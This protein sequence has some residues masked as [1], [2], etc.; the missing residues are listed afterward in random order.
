MSFI[1]SLF[2]GSQAKKNDANALRAQ[3]DQYSGE[4]RAQQTGIVNTGFDTARTDLGTG[5]AGA[6]TDLG[7]YYGDAGHLLDTGYATATDKLNTGYDTTKTGAATDFDRAYG[8]ADT[9]FGDAINYATDY[10][11]MGHDALV[12][13]LGT[14]S[15]ANTALDIYNTGGAGGSPAMTAARASRDQGLL[16]QNQ[17]ALAYEA[18]QRLQAANAG[19]GGSRGGRALLADRRASTQALAGLREADLGHLTEQAQRGQ[20]AATVDAQGRYHTGDVLSSVAGQQGAAKT[21]IAMQQANLDAQIEQAR[22]QGNVALVNALTN[23]KTQLATM[24]GNNLASLDTSE[25][26]AYAGLDTG[27]AGALQGVTNDYYTNLANAAARQSDAYQS[28]RGDMAKA[29]QGYGSLALHAFS[30][31]PL[32]RFGAPGAPG[33]QQPQQYTTPF[34]NFT[35]AV[36]NGFNYASNGLMNL[37]QPQAPQPQPYSYMP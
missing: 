11:N 26:G 31:M 14:G 18:Q 13:Y 36:G 17:E 20:A 34:Q 37:W 12:P 32:P 28:T 10:G 2:G 7:H 19:P 25:G 30:P 27:R 8:F 29:V 4:S 35:S 9:G 1:D 22:T 33:A 23:A 6:R 3:T 16:D 21:Q 5:F 15:R 24:Q